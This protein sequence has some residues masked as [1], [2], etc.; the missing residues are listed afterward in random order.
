[1]GLRLSTDESAANAEQT[2]QAGVKLKHHGRGGLSV[3]A[4]I[5][6]Y[7]GLASSSALVSRPRPT[8]NHEEC[9]HEYVRG[10]FVV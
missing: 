1:M 7:L 6:S 3:L 10:H 2:G 8:A 5:L 4:L 9:V